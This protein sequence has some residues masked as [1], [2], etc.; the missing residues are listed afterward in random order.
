MCNEVEVELDEV[1]P[2]LFMEDIEILESRLTDIITAMGLPEEQTNAALSLMD[3]ALN[4]HHENIL[5]TYE[6][7][8]EE[9]DWDILD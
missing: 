3:A 4:R 5:D 6:D 1:I 7:S 9:Q 8:Y 2:I